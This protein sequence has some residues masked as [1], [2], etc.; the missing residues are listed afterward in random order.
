MDTSNGALRCSPAILALVSSAAIMQPIHAQETQAQPDSAEVERGRGLEEIVVTAQRRAEAL[1]DVPM[2]ISVVTAQAIQ[3]A[4][5]AS[6]HDIGQIVSAVQVNWAGA[7]TQPAIRGVT[8]LT[9]GYGE[10]NVAV[11]VD[12]FYESSTVA[13]NQDLANIEGIQV[14]KGPQGALYGRNATGGAILINTLAPSDTLTGL[15]EVTYARFD[16]QRL[17]GYLSG[18]LSDIFSFSIAGYHRESDGYLDFADPDVHASNPDSPAMPTSKHPAPIEQRAVR[19]KLQADFSEDFTATLAYNYGYSNVINGN[20]Y[21]SYDH[22]PA[23]L[24]AAPRS[25]EVAYN[26]DTVQLAKTHQ[27][28]LKL[29]WGTD[30][31][32]LTSYSGYTQIDNPIRFDFDGT[33]E[34]LTYSTSVWNTRTAQQ[35]FDFA[36]TAIEQLA[37]IVGASYIDDDTHVDPDNLAT[38]YGPG[39]TPATVTNQGMQ[40]QAWAVYADGTYQLTDKVALSAGARYT[41]EKKEAFYGQTIVALGR[42]TAFCPTVKN[43]SF[44]KLTPRASISYALA[45]QTNVYVSYSEGFRSGTLSLSGAATPELWLPVDPEVVD[46]YEVGFK[47]VTDVFRFDIAGFF[48]DDQDLHVSVIEPDP[49]CGGS[50]QGCSVLTVFRNAK[51]AEIYGL[52]GNLAIAPT[53]QLNIRLGAAWLHARYTDFPNASGTSLNPAN[54]LNVSGTIQDWN[55]KEMARAPEFSANI[56]ADY[57][58][59]LPF[60]ALLVAANLSYSDSYVINNP[61]L[62]GGVNVATG[63]AYP[64]EDQRYRQDALSLVTASV[65]WTDP[66]R[67]FTVAVFGTN[68]TDEEY[69][70]TYS[71]TSNFGDYG[72]VAE[73]IN[74]GMRIGY[75]F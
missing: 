38:N 73:P 9:N 20:L 53:E 5:V 27:G 72:V 59:Q 60:G 57:S 14:L 67:H 50:V 23:F 2:S 47:T 69:R 71:G 75:K 25:G 4:G 40:A 61:S 29:E 45:P 30:I 31:G 58:L 64:G 66:G 52:D 37:L 55:G 15:A 68:L 24:P 48:Y 46:A 7:F 41:E 13:I 16:D 49:R 32:T 65:T 6:I 70:V 22:R 35:T 28:T 44:D 17:K 42:C 11:Y 74:Y 33:Y 19:T 34:D 54:G 36:V 10:N 39:R 56:G 43:L 21:T 1:E 8:S 51:G 18:P 3:D 62:F 26:Y 12:G 63:V